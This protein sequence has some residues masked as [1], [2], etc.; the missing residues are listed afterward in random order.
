MPA[1]LPGVL[2]LSDVP[3]WTLYETVDI[4]GQDRLYPRGMDRSFNGQ[5]CVGDA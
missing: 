3:N 2:L 5:Y 4:I 1:M